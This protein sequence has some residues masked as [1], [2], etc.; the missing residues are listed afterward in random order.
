MATRPELG[1]TND[2]S[3]LIGLGPI[4]SAAPVAAF[5]PAQIESLLVTKGF[6]ALHFKHALNPDMENINGVVNP[7]T[8][9][10]QWGVRFFEVRPLKLVPQNFALQHQLTVQGIWGL[11]TVLL[12]I[13]GYYTDF[14]RDGKK[15]LVYAAPDDLIMITTRPDGG[16]VTVE[17]RQ[18]FQYNPTGPMKLNYRVESVYYLA[19]RERRYE[20]DQDFAI[21]DGK[22]VWLPAGR[23]PTSGNQVMTIVYYIKPVYIVKNVPHNVRLLPGNAIGHG[24][25][26]REATYAP[27]LLIAQQSW[28]RQD[29]QELLDFSALPDYPKYAD[30]SNV[31]G[32]TF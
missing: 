13:T 5:N 30:S 18:R 8:Q 19:D 28:I 32:G 6:N 22:I 12:N 21:V 3:G 1:D 26:P 24:G 27:Q 20:Q 15:Q 14:D 7:N 10:A 4:P 23:K 16:A 25:L 17:M 31:S 29:N 2:T 9:A 11:N